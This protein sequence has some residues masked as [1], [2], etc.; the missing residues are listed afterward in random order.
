VLSVSSRS[1]VLRDAVTAVTGGREEI[2]EIGESRESR[3]IGE[4]RREERR[5]QREAGRPATLVP[6]QAYINKCCCCCC[7]CCQT[8]SPARII[9]MR[10][11]GQ[12]EYQ[13]TRF[14][15]EV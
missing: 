6:L 9:Q 11:R 8:S 7:C 2:G 4:R 5:G 10:P 14:R 12:V 1:S 3:E 13:G 15:D